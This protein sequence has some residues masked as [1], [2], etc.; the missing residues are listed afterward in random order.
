M[1]V[2]V[3]VGP[4]TATVESTRYTATVNG[5]IAFVY[6]YTQIT[7]RNTGIWNRG[8]LIE[9]S[10]LKFTADETTTVRIGLSSGSITSA[11][12]YP[13]NHVQQSIQGG[14]LVLTVPARTYCRIEVNGDRKH[15]MHVLANPLPAALGTATNWTTLAKTVASINTGTNVVTMS[16]AHG[17]S[18]GQR[19]IISTTGTLPAVTGDALSV[20]EG[21][22]V[23]SPSGANLQL[24]RTAGGTPIDFTG[25][26]TGTLTLT[27]GDWTSGTLYF[28]PGVHVI[29]RMF[30]LSSNTRL[31]FHL[32]AAVIGA[33]DLRGTDGVKLEGPGHLLGLFQTPQWMETSGLAYLPK[34]EYTMLLGYDGA[35]FAFDNEVRDITIAI[36]PWGTEF[37]CVNR[38]YDT[39]VITPWYYNNGIAPIR[40]NGADNSSYIEHCFIW[41]ADDTWTIGEQAT[42]FNIYIRHS[43][44]FTVANSNVHLSYWPGI[45]L[46]YETVIEECDFMHFG[47]ADVGPGT[48][49]S[50]DPP[51][52]ANV[53]FKS[54]VD[55]FDG[56][57]LAG[58]FNVTVR[59]CRVWGPVASRVFQC[60]NRDY[61]W[62]YPSQSQSRQRKGQIANFVFENIWI[63]EVPGQTSDIFG[64]DWLNTPHDIAFRGI[65]FAGVP[66][67]PENFGDYFTWNVY[68]YRISVEGRTL[69]TAETICNQALAAISAKSRIT[70][71]S[72]PDVG[73]IEAEQCS[74]FYSECIETLLE[75]H[76]WSFATK[77]V[78]LTEAGDTDTTSWLFRYE[79]PG[80]MCR[81]IAVLP[82]GVTHDQMSAGV[83]S[84]VEFVRELDSD[85]VL[86]IYTN[87]ENATLR[88]TA[89]VT[90]PNA[91][92]PLFRQALVALL[93]SKIAGPLWRGTEGD[94]VK[95]RCLRDVEVYLA[96]AK[97]SDASQQK[98]RPAPLVASY[99]QNR[100]GGRTAL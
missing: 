46:G 6:G 88:Y 68:P 8:E 38:W 62:D 50:A 48:D 77:R 14:V 86:R 12:V 21:L 10:W 23:V 28:P 35:K 36:C 78:A 15:T 85:G 60:G 100:R 54:H 45:D 90:N 17:W 39:S 7:G 9:Q 98:V 96:R 41:T 58:R 82:E 65:T 4:G 75:M 40:K 47:K 43:C 73:S 67:V 25:S 37:I 30:K 11:K 20:H 52:G 16:A 49:D 87:E 32:D 97:V 53:I 83:R 5:A 18:A 59:D 42:A 61:I 56:E 81:A 1:T 69:V 89:F 22:W 13:G 3:P 99:M 91:W 72:P 2:N 70:S 34:L 74:R 31:Y 95:Q 24:A 51:W 64:L 44:A 76:E 84:T 80:D 55:G 79:I 71:I 29:S 57:E 19:V 94:N 92:S 93:A 33:I 66:V 27:R 63:E 26:G